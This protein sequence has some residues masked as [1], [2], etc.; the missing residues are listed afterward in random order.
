MTEVDYGCFENGEQ[1]RDS[2]PNSRKRP[3]SK[4]QAREVLDVEKQLNALALNNHKGVGRQWRLHR[5]AIHDG[6]TISRAFV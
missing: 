6:V 2:F 5:E 1:W 3:R 4:R